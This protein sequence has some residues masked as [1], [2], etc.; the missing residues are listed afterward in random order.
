MGKKITVRNPDHPHNQMK[1]MG[2]ATRKDL[3]SMSNDELTAWI[4]RNTSEEVAA[5][6]LP[7]SRGK[8]IRWIVAATER[9]FA[10][11]YEAKTQAEAEEEAARQK[12]ERE[13]KEAAAEEARRKREAEEAELDRLM[14]IEEARNRR[15]LLLVW[16][17]IA[18]AVGTITALVI[19]HA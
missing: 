1:A 6:L 12:A 18:I 5:G 15:N 13:A 4:E 9:Q 11:D 19:L 3:T 7:L 16:A 17:S 2:H 14:A 8:R 10:V